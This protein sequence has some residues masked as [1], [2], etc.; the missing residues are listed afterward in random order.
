MKKIL[1]LLVVLILTIGL[2]A[3][4][5][6]KKSSC[7]K[8]ADSIYCVDKKLTQPDLLFAQDVVTMDLAGT[9]NATPNNSPNASNA[10]KIVV[11]VTGGPRVDGSLVPAKLG[12]NETNTGEPMFVQK[13]AIKVD[14]LL[15]KD[16]SGDGELQPYE[17]WRLSPWERA[18]NL[19]EE[20]KKADTTEGKR[21]AAAM[22]SSQMFNIDHTGFGGNNNG[23]RFPEILSRLNTGE[24]PITGL[25][26]TTGGILTFSNDFNNVR[27]H[28]QNIHGYGTVAPG[29]NTTVPNTHANI[30]RFDRHYMINQSWDYGIS[31]D[32]RGD[33]R[34]GSIAVQALA[35]Q[36]Q[37]GVPF[38]F[39]VDPSTGGAQSNQD[40]TGGFRREEWRGND[41]CNQTGYGAAGDLNYMYE[42]AKFHTAEYMGHGRNIMFGPALDVITEPRWSRVRDS[43]GSEY[44]FVAEMMKAYVRGMQGV[45]SGEGSKKIRYASLIKHI[46]GSGNNAGGTDSHS[47]RW[48]AHNPGYSAGNPNIGR[49]GI[50]SGAWPGMK[51]MFDTVG[52][53]F[54]EAYPVA[55]MPCYGTYAD[56]WQASSYITP[57]G[58]TMKPKPNVGVTGD[59]N[60]MIDILREE[61]GWDGLIGTDYGGYSGYGWNAANL[62][63]AGHPLYNPLGTGLGTWNADTNPN[64]L[65]NT[66][67]ANLQAQ[68]G[69]LCKVQNVG[70]GSWNTQYN[71]YVNGGVSLDW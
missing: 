26:Y 60:F 12:P 2:A 69:E 53:I 39:A 45:M 58:K 1:F 65:D 46:P 23:I 57:S 18:Q 55:T 11:R 68:R 51:L 30:G 22:F 4:G 36:L 66:A 20:I 59:E 3:C 48:H 7:G 27:G 24:S 40:G 44:H 67:V 49:F 16:S 10:S 5:G 42:H 33:I 6:G 63:S 50:G 52:T 13:G 71:A 19:A 41:Y 35:E 31:G 43:V 9:G 29:S 32:T 47:Q 37:F 21:V 54:K 61:W 15:F 14:G 56:P 34:I 70:G 28:I 25:D 38:L 8:N 17:D 64:G 62:R